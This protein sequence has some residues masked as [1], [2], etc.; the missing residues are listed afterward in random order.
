[1]KDN[2]KIVISTAI[3]NDNIDVPQR[4]KEYEECFDII[5]NMGHHDFTI[6]ETALTQSDFLEAYSNKIFYSNCN[7]TSRNRGVN[8]CRA[9]KK[10][11]KKSSLSDDDIILHITGRYPLVNDSFMLECSRLNPDQIGCFKKDP[12]GQF[13]TF[14]F[15]MRR[16]QLLNL[17]SEIDLDSMERNMTCMERIFSNRIDHKKIKFV[18]NLGIRARFSNENEP[19][20]YGRRYF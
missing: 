2:V 4:L 20:K 14:L 11:L 8:H 12:L 13:Y 3:I 9:L 6:L 10:Y 16:K 15:G 18:E 5:K 19:S 1:M 7:V 17:L